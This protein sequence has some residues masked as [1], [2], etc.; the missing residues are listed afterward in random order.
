MMTDAIQSFISSF[1]DGCCYLAEN[2]IFFENRIPIKT[3]KTVLA[4]ALVN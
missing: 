1:L 3:I 2:D 4:L